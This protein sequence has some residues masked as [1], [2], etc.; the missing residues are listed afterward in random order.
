V[1]IV[2]DIQVILSLSLIGSVVLLLEAKSVT[3]TLAKEA[4]TTVMD[5]VWSLDT[6]VSIWNIVALEQ[7][8]LSSF[9]M[10]VSIL[11]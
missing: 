11:F 4:T 2:D 1:H 3:H 8:A 5:R 9:L 10:K 7:S 6:P